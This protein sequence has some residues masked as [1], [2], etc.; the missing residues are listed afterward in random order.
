MDEKP[1]KGSVA[2]RA[3]PSY[4]HPLFS[5]LHSRINC[6]LACLVEACALLCLLHQKFTTPSGCY[7]MWG[8]TATVLRIRFQ[9]LTSFTCATAFAIYTFSLCSKEEHPVVGCRGGGAVHWSLVLYKG[10]FQCAWPGIPGYQ[11]ALQRMWT[12][13]FPLSAFAHWGCQPPILMCAV[14]MLLLAPVALVS[15]VVCPVLTLCWVALCVLKD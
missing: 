11:P 15:C 9:G 1:F 12:R 7:I 6:R 14:V 2:E 3:L 13:Y 10:V 5:A 8:C 4:P